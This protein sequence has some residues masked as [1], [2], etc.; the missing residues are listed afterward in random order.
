MSSSKKLDMR[1]RLIALGIAIVIVVGGNY[2]Y[3]FF[4]KR[5]YSNTTRV[6]ARMYDECVD[7]K[8]KQADRLPKDKKPQGQNQALQECHK[9]RE[10]CTENFKQQLCLLAQRQFIDP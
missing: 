8:M 9:I 10:S 6:V 2:L 7:Y 3:G 1:T 5:W 4:R